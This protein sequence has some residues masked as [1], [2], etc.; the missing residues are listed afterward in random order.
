VTTLTELVIGDDGQHGR[1]TEGM[2][3]INLR[4][5]D[6]KRGASHGNG[7]KGNQVFFWSCGA[8]GFFFGH[9]AQQVFVLVMWRSRFFFGHVAQQVFF[10]VM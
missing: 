9:V 7:H 3:A 4:G 10:L 2:H 6:F 1:A 8:A 5:V